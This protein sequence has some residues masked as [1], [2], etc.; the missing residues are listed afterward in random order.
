L[1]VSCVGTAAL[2]LAY[3]LWAVREEPSVPGMLA[4]GL[5]VALFVFGCWRFVP[6]WIAFFAPQTELLPAGKAPKH[7]VAGVALLAFAV[8]ALLFGVVTL[9]LSIR[10]GNGFTFKTYNAN[11]MLNAI[12]RACEAYNDK[13]G[14]QQLMRRA[15]DCDYSWAVSADMYMET[16]NEIL[17]KK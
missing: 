13:N 6:G 16:Y 5:S 8:E 7:A 2:L 3:V 15:M 17:E 4:A 1:I 12:K 11:D 14:W 9:I 10:N